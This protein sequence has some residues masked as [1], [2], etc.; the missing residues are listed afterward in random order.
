MAA[1]SDRAGPLATPRRLLVVGGLGFYGR[2]VCRAL[3]ERGHEVVAASRRGG[4]NGGLR[5]DLCDRS[6]F[7]AFEGFDAV[8]NASDS[9]GAPSEAA[10]RWVAERGSVWFEMGADAAAVDRLLALDLSGVRGTVL[11][12]VGVFPGMSTA[13]ARAVAEDGPRC[14]R[15]EVVIRFSPLS[16]A[17]LANCRLMAHS[18]FVPASH[19]EG[20]ARVEGRRAV[21]D[22]AAIEIAGSVRRA[23][24]ITLPDTTLVH[25]ATRAPRVCARFDLVP[26][27]LRFNFAALAAIAAALR[28]A[29]PA[30]TWALTWQLALARAV[31]LRRVESRVELWAIADRDTPNQ[32]SRGLSFDDGQ[33][34]TALGAAL[35][36]EAWARVDQPIPP[37]VHGV[38]EVFAPDA[39]IPPD[40]WIPSGG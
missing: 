3:G 38:A 8:V 28:W 4:S 29:R 25:R 1:S 35:A 26:G 9:V 15:C 24:E 39:L 27:W 34:A 22:A 7:G 5:V 13:L 16:G 11:V 40:A 30:V 17:G 10:A 21:G 32:R 6:T 37:G 12:G 33:E 14:D 20:G 18:L 19:V 2:R 31:L 23:V 36:V